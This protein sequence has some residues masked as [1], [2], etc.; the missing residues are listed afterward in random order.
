MYWEGAGRKWLE[1]KIRELSEGKDKI[2]YLNK[3][4]GYTGI[5]FVRIQWTT[6]FVL[7]YCM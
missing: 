5:A 6:R 1:R 2:L 3:G 4:L 7:F